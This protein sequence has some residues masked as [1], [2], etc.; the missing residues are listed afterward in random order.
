[1]PVALLLATHAFPGKRLVETLVT[2]PMVP[3]HGVDA[4]R[5]LNPLSAVEAMELYLWDRAGSDN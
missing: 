1:M 5:L 4:V 3:E 2:L